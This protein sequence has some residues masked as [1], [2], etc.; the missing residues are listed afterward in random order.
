MSQT[1]S[2]NLLQQAQTGF[3]DADSYDTYRP[4]YPD[5]AVS[6]LL[7]SLHVAGRKGATV[8]DL[9]AGTGK[10]TESLARR[11]EG[12]NIIAV[13]PHDG[14][15]RVLE[16]K[17][18]PNVRSVTGF[19]EHMPE[20]ADETI[21]A[22]IASQSFHWFATLKA[23][24]E[25]YRVIKPNGTLGMIWNQDAYN[26][27]QSWALGDPWEKKLRDLLW[28]YDDGQPRFR[29]EQWKK[30]FD[31]QLKGTP[32]SI[33]TGADPMF[34]LPIGEQTF[35]FVTWLSK[36][37]ISKRYR[38]LSHIA[39]LKGEDEEVSTSMISL[40]LRWTTQELTVRYT[41]SQKHHCECTALR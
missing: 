41:E 1:T 40:K 35:P 19:A 21:D 22:V 7:E 4:S 25:I 39:N 31:E 9:A 5:E 20:I 13:E 36:V 37:E 8:L 12:Y 23:L 30:V 17:N 34:S 2:N 33:V 3:S 16:A 11:P 14:M 15:R 32:L 26:A 24:E 29:H 27:P 10:F 6:Q 38:T 28:E 18:L